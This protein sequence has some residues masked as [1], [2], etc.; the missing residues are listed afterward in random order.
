MT[1]L[2]L[3]KQL[4]RLSEYIIIIK[5]NNS[6]NYK[7]KLNSKQ[8]NGMKIIFIAHYKLQYYVR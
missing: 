6:V 7:S 5:I 1:K 2:N 8:L 3:V 4:I